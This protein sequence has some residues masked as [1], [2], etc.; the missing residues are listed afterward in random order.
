MIMLEQYTEV[1]F[2]TEEALIAEAGY[3]ALK[4][5]IVLHKELTEKIREI[6]INA[7]RNENS[8]KLLEFLKQWWLGHINKED[9][10][11]APFV[12]KLLDTKAS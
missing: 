9:R 1:H 11:Y 2:K 3:P 4:E 10:K 5:H 7:N 6:S 8:D 12:R